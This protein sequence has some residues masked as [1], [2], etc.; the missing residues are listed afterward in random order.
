MTTFKDDTERFDAAIRYA[1]SN[2]KRIEASID[3]IWN[4][5][6]NQPQD[7]QILSDIDKGLFDGLLWAG[8]E[9]IKFANLLEWMKKN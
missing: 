1:K 9:A 6:P 8:H 3:S 4:R 5:Y 7:Y 2:A